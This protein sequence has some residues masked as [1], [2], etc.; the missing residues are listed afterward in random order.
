MGDDIFVDTATAG[1]ATIRWDATNK[2]DGSD[3]KFSVTLYTDGRIRFDYGPG[4]ANLTPS[5]G[6]SRG[7]NRNY[8]LSTHD[9]QTTLGNADSVEFPLADGFSYV[10]LGAY[11]FGG[12]SLDM[13]PPTVLATTPTAIHDA[14]GTSLT[15][16][17]IDVTFSEPLNSIDAIAPANYGLRGAG[18]DGVF[19]NGDDNLYGLTPSYVPGST[20]VTLAVGGGALPDGRFRLTIS[21]TSSI[22][23][24]SGLRL[25][26]DG[27]G[28]AGG[29]YV[30]TFTVDRTAP[31]VTRVL[32]GS[33]QW[34]PIFGD[35]MTSLASGTI[36]GYEIPSGLEQLRALPWINLNQVIVEF[37]EDVAVEQNDLILTGVAVPWYAIAGFNYNSMAHVAVWTL[38]QT[39]PFDALTVSLDGE[40][41]LAV[42]DVAGNLLD[43][44]WIDQTS[45]FPSGNSVTGGDFSFRLNVVPADVNQDGVVDIFD[46]NLISSNWGSEGPAGNVNGDDEVDIFDINAVS[47]HWGA[48]A[49]GDVTPPTTVILNVSPD[50]RANGSQPD[51]DHLQ[52]AGYWVHSGR[53]FTVAR[54]RCPVTCRSNALDVR[55]RYVDPRQSGGTDGARRSIPVDRWHGDHRPRGKLTGHRRHGDVDRQSSRRRQRRW[56]R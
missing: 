23:D 50:P 4:N 18:D 34:T 52:R 15:V 40:T 29:D 20:L 45:A 16:S 1:Q 5:V 2:V 46:V 47:A 7:N 25:D 21:G 49:P 3:V 19:N 26:G 14:G 11:E 53:C 37:S 38:A 39:I 36:V 33:T 51:F 10:D 13:T 24:A 32:V 27:D 54:R 41:P 43:G 17:Q 6:I 22:H 9:G 28:A 30:R 56:C 42:V 12:S 44:E 8:R 48:A 31:R 55:F 35:Q